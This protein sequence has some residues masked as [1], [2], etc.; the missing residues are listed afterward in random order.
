MS[1]REQLRD[2]LPQI[3]PHEPSDA[4]KGTEL[5][6][7]V[8]VK[9]KDDYSDAT[10]RYHFSILSY[11]PSSPIAKVDQGQGYYLR[12]PVRETRV[13]AMHLQFFDPEGTPKDE[14][15]ARFARF[16]SIVERNSLH[17]G[18]YPFAL[19]LAPGGHWELPDIILTDWDFETDHDET[20]RLDETMLNL[21]RFLAAPPVTLTAAQL[22]L[23]ITLESFNADFFQT[24]SATR[25]ANRGE[26]IIAS[27]VSDEAL[28]EA[29]RVLGHQHDIG[30][31]SYGMDLGYLDELPSADEIRSMTHQ[32]FESLQNMLK[33]QRISVGSI[34]PYLDWK[35]LSSLKKKHQNLERMLRWLHDCL[36]MRRPVWA[37]SGH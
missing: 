4:I 22:K 1:L 11:D 10:L 5:I 20:P 26:I 31:T 13:E 9:L 21:K 32:E 29:L 3:L 37:G 16:R 17:S 8:R 15:T 7:L 33:L 18:H 6:R 23:N 30:I 19:T 25:W 34:R 27:K 2:I 12:V 14:A 24:V 36:D 28:V 35:H